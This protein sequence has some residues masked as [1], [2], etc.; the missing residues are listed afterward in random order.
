MVANRKETPNFF[1]DIDI[2]PDP[3]KL[4]TGGR[5]KKNISIEEQNKNR[6]DEKK[7]VR[8]K[9]KKNSKLEENKKAR[10]EERK[11][12]TKEVKKKVGYYLPE[13]LIASIDKN[14]YKLKLDGKDISNKSDLLEQIVAFGLEDLSK[15][16]KSKI[17]K[18]I[19]KRA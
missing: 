11:N 2:D 4:A 5:K 19:N 7:N 3:V 1:N 13:S 16:G 17:L 8:K 6:I 10:K 15:G 9:D 12:L 14:F 18:T